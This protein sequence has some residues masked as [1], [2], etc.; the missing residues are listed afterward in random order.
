M[1]QTERYANKVAIVTGGA[2]GIGEAVVRQ[3]VAEGAR[4]MAADI[5]VVRLDAL[6]RELGDQCATIATDVTQEKEVEAMVAA[7]VK[8]FGKLDV[9]FNIAGAARFG[10]LTDLSEADWHVAIGI[11]LTGTFLC[12]KHEARQM[13]ATGTRG[14]IVNVASLNSQVPNVGLSSYCAAKAGVEMLGKCGCIELGPHGIRVNT[15]SPG[16]TKTPP[17]SVMTPEV[18]DAYCQRIPLARQASASEQADVCLFLGSDSS[19]YVTGTNV[20]V[21][22]GWAH[23]AY[24]IFREHL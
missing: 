1:T 11:C 17:T 16:L 13:I 8:R 15:V 5:N 21:D 9:A 20:F 2:S 10:Q 24:P 22:G 14:A 6:A 7:T 19:S 23:A 3:L 4:L 18:L 12:M